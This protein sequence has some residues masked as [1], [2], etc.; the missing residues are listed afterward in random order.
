MRRIVVVGASLAAVHAIDRLRDSGYQG[1]IALVGA[2]RRLPYDRPPLSKEALRTGPDT[3]KLLLKQPDWY[4]LR[5][6]ELR[7][8]RPA[9]GLDTR[10]RRVRLAGGACLGYDGLIIATGS[11]A[12]RFPLFDN[13]AHAHTVR[14]IDDAAALRTH[15]A[16]GSHL[17]VIGA[18]FIGL[19]VAATASA[20][21][22][23]VSVVETAPTPLTR[24][25]GCEVGD[26]FRRLHQSHGVSIYCDNVI[27]QV[28]RNGHGWKLHLRDGTV[29]AADVVL[30]GVGAAPATGWLR[31][32]GVAVSDGVV[33]D[34]SL[35]TSAPGVVAAGDVAR[36]YNPLFDESMRVEQWS[37]AV[38][39]GRKAAITLLGGAE[40]FASVP[41]FW[42]DQFDAKIR[43]AG[44]ANGA[45]HVHIRQDSDTSLVALFGAGGLIRGALCVNE[46]RK[47]A[48]YRAAIAA[49]AP[50][51]D[52][53]DE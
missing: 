28:E 37:N 41:Y 26:W 8:G 7:L 46:P 22:M 35:R 5:D 15:L 47:L 17:V 20:I 27:K 25:L 19:E 50:W 24:V 43:F 21:G 48:H 33:C 45:E 34:S 13:D 44:R 23:D 51:N 36:W 29:L 3:A 16:A 42:S 32:S 38:E 31:G 2:E 18:G 14:T 10:R 1:Q 9:V 12:R 52:V 39:L 4:A 11:Q 30:A 53:I 49:Q 6:I 40:P